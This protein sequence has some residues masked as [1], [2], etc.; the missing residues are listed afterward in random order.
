VRRR[1]D[2]HLHS[3]TPLLPVY[4]VAQLRQAGL[5]PAGSDG[6]Y[7]PV[8]LQSQQIIEKDSSL[9]LI[10]NGKAEPL[11]LG[12][13]DFLG[14]RI[15]LAPEVQAPLVFVGYGPAVPEQDYDDL[16]GL[17]LKGKVAVIVTGSP[18]EIAGALA[19][20]Y[21]SSAERWKAFRKAEP[22]AS[23]ASPTLLVSWPTWGVERGM[24]RFSFWI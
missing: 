15:D 17:D 4:V 2:E 24:F 22:S 8:K 20:H 13:D 18:S 11:T 6:Y 21:Q 23:L 12:E 5:Q 16:A 10:R 19:A 7:Q 14:T 9:T 1:P 3:T